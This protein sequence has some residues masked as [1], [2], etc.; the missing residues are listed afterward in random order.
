MAYLTG[1]AGDAEPLRRPHQAG[2]GLPRRARPVVR[3]RALGGAGRLLA[4]D[5]R[6]RDRR[7]HRGLAHRPACTATRAHARLYQAVADDFQR[8]VKGFT[9]T[10]NGPYSGAPYFIRLSK[11]GDPNSEFTYGLGNGSVNADQRAVVDGGFQEL[12]RLGELPADDPDVQ[13]SLRCSTSSSA[14]RRRPAPATTATARRTAGS[15]DGYGDC[16][17]PDPT[18]CPQDGQPWPTT[19]TGSGHLWPVLSGERAETALADGDTDAG[20]HAARLHAGLRV[21]GRTGAGAGLGGPRPGRV[22]VRQRPDHRLDRLPR[23]PRRPA[24]PL[25]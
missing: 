5:D 25:R 18:N 8:T 23:R 12:V 16:Y 24:R 20:A 17:T 7:A 10:H 2:R 1:L 6:R 14:R 22:A 21:R 19:D 13:N 4:L 3:Q 11:N 15:E 9:V